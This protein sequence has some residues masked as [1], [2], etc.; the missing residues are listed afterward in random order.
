MPVELTAFVGEQ[1]AKLSIAPK[2]GSGAASSV[3]E[4]KTNFTIDSGDGTVDQ[5]EDGLSAIIRSSV[6]GDVSGKVGADADPGPGEVPLQDTFV[7]HF[8]ARLAEDLGLS[9]EVIPA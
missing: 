9:G 6:V 8:V 4:G 7:I 3:E 1:A 5:A 2:T